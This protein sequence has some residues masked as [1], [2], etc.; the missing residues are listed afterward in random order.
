VNAALSQVGDNP[1]IPTA[2]DE[3]PDDWLDVNAE[4]F[5]SMLEKNFG[6]KAAKGAETKASS[7][8]MDVDSTDPTKDTKTLEDQV[9][10]QQATRLKNLAQKVEEFVEGEGDI[11]GAR[12]AD[13]E[14]SDEEFSDDKSDTSDDNS[15]AE[16]PSQHPH[17]HQS[18]AERAARQ[19][20]MDKLVPGLDPSE[21]GKMPASFHSNSQRVAPTT[22][23]TEMREDI[24]SGSPQ[25][26]AEP[27]KRSI[28]PPIIPRDKYDGVD[29][30]DETDEEDGGDGD[31]EEEEDQPQVV[32]DVEI[33]MEEEEDEFLEFARQAL[34]MSDA[35]WGDIVKERKDRGA[36][37]PTHVTSESKPKKVS[38]AVPS[39]TRPPA[40]ADAHQPRR[41]AAGPRPNVNPNLDSFEAVMQAMDAELARSRAGKQPPSTESKK[42]KAKG[43]AKA[44]DVDAEEGEEVDIEAAMDAELKAALERE[45]DGDEED[46]EVEGEVDYN[47]IKNFLESFKGQAGLSGPVGNLAGRLQSGWTLPR[48]QS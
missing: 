29:S 15:D 27:R 44:M 38:D 10:E 17:S 45:H 30:D 46:G 41:P 35:Q 14:L 13:E 36:Y 20:A 5:D 48:D 18:E 25:S 12:F 11:D 34:G 9:A 3:D 7:D 40:S 23:E 32:G 31:E 4:D 16:G 22:M 33:D 6:T 2:Q 28:R 26:T 43:K 21:Y 1:V 39:Q 19:A 24:P 47:L 8:V 42:D 37:V